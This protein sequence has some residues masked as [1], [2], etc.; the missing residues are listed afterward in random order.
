[1]RFAILASGSKG[2]AA[3]VEHGNDLVIIDCGLSHTQ[4]CKRMQA[5]GVTPADLTAILLTHEHRDHIHGLKLL[6]HYTGLIPFM[7][8]GTA[9]RLA[10]GSADHR[11]IRAGE[12]FTLTGGLT[13][14]PYTIPHDASE[15]VQFKF[16]VAGATLCF[17]TDIGTPNDYVTASLRGCNALVLECNY[18]DDMLEGNPNYPPTLKNRIRG[19]KG[20]LSNYQAADLLARVTHPHLR[21]VVAA[22]LSAKNNQ[23]PL[24]LETLAARLL[25][26]GYAPTLLASQQDIPTEWFEVVATGG[27]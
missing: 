14:E 27:S 19:G 26:S 23:A 12:I 11:S 9:H 7:T 4:L 8:R 22:H 5:V 6:A 16:S 10:L 25:N 24:V 18:D 13:V 2:N 20:H 1:M 15:A 17:A 3:L 21:L